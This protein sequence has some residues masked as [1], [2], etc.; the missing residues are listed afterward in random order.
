MD[1]HYSE[2]QVAVRDLAKQILEDRVPTDGILKL[3][4]ADGW[5][6]EGTWQAL[7][8]ASLLGVALPEAYGGAG[9]GLIELALILEEA[10]RRIAPLPLI[11][12]LVMG[13][14]PIAE[15]GNDEQKQA[16]LPGVVKGE[17]FLT[18]ALVEEGR[19]DA[20][21]PSTR[22]RA[23]GDGFVLSG[24]KTCVPAAS[25]AARILVPATTDD[26]GVAVFLLDPG[27]SGVTLQDQQM[28]SGEPHSL[29][30][31]ENVPVTAGDR[32]GGS[33]QG[34]AILR[35][36]SDR[37]M[38]AACAVQLGIADSALEQTAAYQSER[39]QFGVAIGTFQGPQLRAADAWIDT[40]AMRATL[41]QAV[42]RVATDREAAR[43]I[44]VAKWWACRG[45]HR[46][47]HACQ[48]LHG[49]IGAD[50]EYPIHRWFL[51]AKQNEM[52]LGGASLH[53]ARLGELLAGGEHA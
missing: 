1:F 29:L 38:V 20:T 10:G 19:R 53:Q 16:N 18:A 28:T 31:L 6:D 49:G 3:L 44:Q 8:Q 34:P 37:T 36:I 48:H 9:M 46:V 4:Q 30:T 50:V 7:A 33:E 35:W 47:S 32:L 14:L 23:E 17:R 25:I 39:K 42:W 12:T 21:R 5:Y 15:F 22:A 27:T 41:Q 13:A 40:E 43:E 45:G 24:V 52:I 2:D 51:A 11:P 26:G